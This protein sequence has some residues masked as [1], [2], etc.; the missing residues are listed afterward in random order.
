VRSY[1]EGGYA[2]VSARSESGMRVRVL[3]DSGPLGYGALAAHGHAD[4]LSLGLWAGE[5]LLA[6]PGTGSYHGDPE[7]RERLRGA[8]AHN[9]VSVDGADPAERKGLFLWGRRPEARLVA[10]GGETPW[11]V[12]AGAH[13]GYARQGVPQVRRLAIGWIGEGDIV[14]L[15]V[16]EV[17]GG[18][19]HRIRMPWHLGEGEPRVEERGKAPL[20]RARYPSGAVL[21]ARARMSDGGELNA[22][23]VF[24]GDPVS[25]GWHA[26]RFEERAA[27]GRIAAAASATLP[28]SLVWLLHAR[29]PSRSGIAGVASS[30]AEDSQPA[31]EACDGGVAAR[32]ALGGGRTFR[33]LIAGPASPVARAADAAL[34]GS[35]AAWIDDSRPTGREPSACVAGGVALDASGI[36]WRSPGP[37]VT[38]VL[39]AVRPAENGGSVPAREG[40]RA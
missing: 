5:D 28:A 11:W 6:D 36:E 26:P 18:S 35:A 23:A 7:W 21:A 15:V 33:A 14:V 4:A 32:L 9:T 39:S 40:A 30:P 25:G 34:D 2:L 10:A 17:A 16:D 12:L 13:D 19:S 3:F 1:P 31:L 38:G 29:L 24:G 22:E 20:F 27:G 8:A 37:P